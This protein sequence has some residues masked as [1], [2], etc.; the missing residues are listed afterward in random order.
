MSKYPLAAAAALSALIASSAARAGSVSDTFDVSVTVTAS[1]TVDTSAATAGFGSVPGTAL[2]TT[3]TSSLSVTCTNST[4]FD[5]TLA[6][7]TGGNGKFQ[8]AGA[9]EN[10]GYTVKAGGTPVTSG[11][12][13]VT[14]GAG[15]GSPV[16]TTLTFGF[17]QATAP[18]PGL[19]KDTVTATVDF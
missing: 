10:V 11:T 9:K 5:L 1:C 7:A 4:P 12:K 15:T 17:S 14:F 18:T 2:K 16:A 19:Y 13:L 3:A 6:S 8:M